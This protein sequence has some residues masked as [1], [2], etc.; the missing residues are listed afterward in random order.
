MYKK[1]PLS[2]IM[3]GLPELEEGRRLARLNRKLL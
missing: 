1:E 3:E 2:E